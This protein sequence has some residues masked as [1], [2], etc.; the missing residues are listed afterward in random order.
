[1]INCQTAAQSILGEKRSQNVQGP[2]GVLLWEDD[3]PGSGSGQLRARRHLHV[4]HQLARHAADYARDLGREIQQIEEDGD[5]RAFLVADERLAEHVEQ[6][7][8]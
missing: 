3:R 5:L 2:R 1:M 8:I 7:L 4:L 6:S